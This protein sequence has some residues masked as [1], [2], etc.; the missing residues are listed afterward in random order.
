MWAPKAT[1]ATG[2]SLTG[3]WVPQGKNLRVSFGKGTRQPH[4]ALPCPARAPVWKEPT[5]ATGGPAG[6]SW[7]DREVQKLSSACFGQWSLASSQIHHL[8][9][10][11]VFPETGRGK[12]TLSGG[13]E[14]STSRSA[15]RPSLAQCRALSVDWPGPRSPHRLYLTV[16]VSPGQQMQG[17]E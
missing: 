9:R 10:L 14:D 6:H 11:S 4:P 15:A 17:R 12:D 16:Q 1:V 7:A 8:I 13:E 2:E 5:E 3:S